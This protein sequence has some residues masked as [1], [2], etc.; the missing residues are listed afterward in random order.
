MFDFYPGLPHVVN[1]GMCL[2]VYYLHCTKMHENIQYTCT[3]LLISSNSCVLSLGVFMAMDS[4]APWN[5]TYTC[6]GSNSYHI[7][8]KYVFPDDLCI[9]SLISVCICVLIA[10]TMMNSTWNTRKFLALMR[11]PRDSRWAWYCAWV[12]TWR[13][14]GGERE[15]LPSD[16]LC[17]SKRLRIGKGL[18][19]I[20]L[21]GTSIRY[22]W[23]EHASHTA[24][25]VTALSL[26]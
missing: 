10:Y 24:P 12:T 26:Q 22:M 5:N 25:L 18:P 7:R 11:M 14:G 20:A 4:T 3:Y 15:E 23:M 1:P 17:P 13:E 16:K 19:N 2:H 6:S 21:P 9:C 8:C